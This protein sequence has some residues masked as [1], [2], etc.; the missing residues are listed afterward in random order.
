VGL[1]NIP[2]IKIGGSCLTS[3]LSLERLIPIC[4]RWKNSILV[5]SAFSGV[6]DSLY[7]G[8]LDGNTLEI[9]KEMISYHANILENANC[10]NKE[11]NKNKLL[12][13]LEFEDERN[14]DFTCPQFN[15]DGY[16]SLGEQLSAATAFIFLSQFVHTEYI[17]SHK[18]TVVIDGEDKEKSVD[19][20]KSKSK[21]SNMFVESLGQKTIL[22]T[23]FYGIA[24]NNMFKILGRNSSDYSASSI[25]AIVG[26]KQ[27]ILFKDVDGIY[28]EDPKL[29]HN[30]LP[31]KAMNLD[32]L[33]HILTKG[34]K[35]I[36]EKVIEV[37]RKYSIS[38]DVVN[39]ENGIKGTTIS[40]E[41]Q[42][43]NF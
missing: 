39:F 26:S 4:E 9:T 19:V 16:I 8:I 29:N 17:P 36:H 13:L 21:I 27:L 28:M 22:T 38:I 42:E 37:C 1:T 10:G 12:Q 41:I 34:S 40:D 25:A 43:N 3:Y 7:Q 20:A 6:T 11:D 2:V 35:I 33:E 15:P 18:L 32:E 30:I 24:E 23:G 14:F 5:F 31:L